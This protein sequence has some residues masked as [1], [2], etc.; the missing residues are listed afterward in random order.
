MLGKKAAYELFD[1]RIKKFREIGWVVVNC[2]LLAQNWD[3]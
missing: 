1:R 2:I 3:Q